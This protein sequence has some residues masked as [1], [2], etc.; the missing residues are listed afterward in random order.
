MKRQFL[1]TV[2]T[3][4]LLACNL[5]FTTSCT[6]GRQGQAD[7]SLLP[8][9]VGDKWGYID[10][11]GKYVI[12]PQFSRAYFFY[13]GLAKV[14]MN[15]EDGLIDKDGH[16]V[17]LPQQ[18]DISQFANGRVWCS[19][20]EGPL[21]I[22]DGKGETVGVCM[23]AFK[24]YPFSD[25]IAIVDAF[26]NKEYVVDKSGNTLFTLTEGLHFPD[27]YFS[28][29]LSV[30]FDD[31]FKNGY[32]N[33]KGDLVISCRFKEAFPFHGGQAIVAPDYGEYGVIDKEGNY[34]INPQFDFIRYDNNLYIIKIGDQY[35]WCDRKGK[36][37]INPQFDLVLPFF[38]NDLAPVRIND[39]WGYVDKKG[40]LKIN[41][42][43]DGALSF[44]PQGTAWVI[45]GNKFGL[46]NTEGQFVVNPQ[47]DAIELPHIFSPLGRD[48]NVDPVISDHF[49]VEGATAHIM[50]LLADNCF[51]KMKITQTSISDFRKKYELKKLE[52]V[53]PSHSRGYSLYMSYTI[54]AEGTFSRRVS[55]GWWGTKLEQLPNA[56][57]E[58]ICLNLELR[59]KEHVEAFYNSLQAAL[60]GTKGQR[61][62][63]QYYELEKG[64]YVITL[65]VSDKKLD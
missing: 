26:E 21:T 35:G 49:Y 31:T 4:C 59:K 12:N 22:K 37:V 43:F 65:R 46:I 40:K 41:P 3:V 14:E 1:S 52:T 47:F 8:V 10:H 19:E 57:L 15:G 53:T 61:D 44:M 64:E 42:Q 56:K 54:Q 34:V 48:G 2:L 63:G 16:Y 9:K 36:I 17:I 38:D 28:E 58:A 11:E 60:G 62:S 29:G 7:Y 51:D 27:A 33:K 13:E 5:I 6:S 30:V 24:A 20:P 50:N 18:H 45:S 32:I 23:D 55:D 25:G 39:K